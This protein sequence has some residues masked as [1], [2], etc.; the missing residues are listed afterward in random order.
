MACS[1][2]G[3]VIASIARTQDAATWIG[4]FFT[5]ATTMLGGTFFTI[6]KGTF[7]Y[8]LSRFSINTYANGA[9]QGLISESSHIADLGTEIAVLVGVMVVGLII[10][11]L[12]FK[13][14]PGGK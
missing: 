6:Q 1:A 9:F 2:I 11:R 4:V 5:M 8:T 10:S 14:I 3:L 13:V 7:L 12:L